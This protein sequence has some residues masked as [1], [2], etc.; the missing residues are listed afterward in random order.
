[1]TTYIYESDSGS[2]SPK[3]GTPLHTRNEDHTRTEL[4][5]QTFFGRQVYEY[6]VTFDS[7][8]AITVSGLYWIGFEMPD[9]TGSGTS[10]W[11]TSDGGDG[12][13][14]TGWL[15]FNDGIDWVTVVSVI[16]RTVWDFAFEIF[17]EEATPPIQDVATEESICVWPPNHKLY[18]HDASTFVT[19]TDN[20]DEAS[21]IV[22]DYTNTF[23]CT[24]N[25][26]P[27]DGTTGDGNHSPDCFYDAENEQVCFRA[28]RQGP[29]GPDFEGRSYV[30]TVE[31]KDTIGN[32]ATLTRTV[33][34]PHD[35]EHDDV[36]SCVPAT[37]NDKKKKDKKK[38]GR[39]FLRD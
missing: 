10:Y 16:P 32:V 27:I 39:K 21:S 38:N 7:P 8:I 1:M 30:V 3:S 13:D 36:T 5:G 28:E 33:I 34:V 18:C 23:S 26:N 15:S 35:D 4:V 6:Y 12:T 17:A 31:A 37:I 19:A 22:I 25:Q 24:S 14:N 11:T 29:D 20:C 2:T 9:A